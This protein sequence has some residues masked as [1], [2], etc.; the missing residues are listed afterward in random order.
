MKILHIIPNLR[1]GGAERLVIDIVRKLNMDPSLDVKLVLFENQIDYQVCDLEPIIEIIPS[2]VRLSL[3]KK[4]EFVINSLQSFI[5][6]FQPAIIHSHL[7]YAEIVSRS[8]YYPQAKWFSHVHDRMQSLN[9]LNLFNVNTKRELTN[10]FE[11]KYL[12]KRYKKNGNN[13][14]ISISKDVES[15]LIKVIQKNKRIFLLPNAI[16]LSRFNRPFSKNE[17][18]QNT[19]CKLV[20]IGRL[21]KNKN[22]EFLL[23]CMV[24][25]KSINV[26]VH[27]TILGE[28][29]QRIFL[30]KKNLI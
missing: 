12:M 1:K 30:E 28:G 9:N 22:H 21:D 2:H 19:L 14:F 29:D 27:L 20:S 3:F 26:P 6:G 24:V 10:Y 15:F 11:K 4:N 23:D 18:V 7:Y 13:H 17:F 25:L 8:C 16:D 5:E